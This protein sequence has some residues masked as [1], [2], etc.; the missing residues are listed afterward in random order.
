MT[1]LLTCPSCENKFRVYVEGTALK[2]VIEEK[3][4]IEHYNS[5]AFDFKCHQCKNKVRVNKTNCV[6]VS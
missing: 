3:I 2:E 4:T 6:I 5:G 1:A